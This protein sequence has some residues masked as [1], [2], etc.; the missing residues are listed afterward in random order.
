MPNPDFWTALVVFCLGATIG[1]FLN[2]VIW[3]L[4][5]GEQIASGRSHC[6]SCSKDLAPV[7]LIPF[8]SFIVSKGCCRY[9]KTRISRRYPIIELATAWLFLIAYYLFVPANALGWFDLAMMM[10][11][12][13]VLVVIFVIDFEHYLILDKVVW[14]ATAII[15]AAN[16]GRDIYI[17][18]A[19][20]QGLLLESL[21]GAVAGYVPFYLIWKISQG[22]WIG[23][24]DAKLGLFLGAV[25]GF[26]AVWFGFLLAFFIGT[27]VAVPLLLLGKKSMGSKLPLGTFLAVSGVLNLWFGEAI[28]NWYLGLIGFGL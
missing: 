17:G 12:M 13:A 21:V 23:L 14:P 11:V 19:I 5:R 8:I 28:G 24:G 22:K 10:F 27:V 9:C 16:F 3:R 18:N 26:P 7:D 4:P 25:L 6:P 15:L 2:V 1:S 20:L